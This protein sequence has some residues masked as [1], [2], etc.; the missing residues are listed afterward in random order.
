MRKKALPICGIYKI[1]N[2]IG[3]IYIGKSVHCK[4]RWRQNAYQRQRLIIESFEKYGYKNHTFEIIE[5]CEEEQLNDREKFWVKHFD[6]FDTPNGL[7]L[8]GGSSKGYEFSKQSREIIKNNSTGNNNWEGRKHTEESKSKIGKAH[9]GRKHTEEARK[10]MG[11]GQKGR[12]ASDETR[13]IMSE[14]RKG[15]PKPIGFVAHTAKVVLN[16]ETGVYYVS[17]REAAKSSTIKYDTLQ[18]MLSGK[19]PNKSQ[20]IYA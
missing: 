10:N 11:Q 18:D 7:N 16:T 5:E 8:T 14:Q 4:R 6:C 1:T 20:F 19:R 2:P 13:K 15:I 9:K 3:Q 17:L 12:K